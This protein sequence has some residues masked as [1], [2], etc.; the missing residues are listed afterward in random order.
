MDKER[1][2]R[3]GLHIRYLENVVFQLSQKATI[4][5]SHYFKELDELKRESREMMNGT[6]GEMCSEMEGRKGHRLTSVLEMNES[7]LTPVEEKVHRAL[8]LNEQIK[9]E[10]LAKWVENL[11]IQ[12]RI[13]RM[14]VQEKEIIP[15]FGTGSGSGGKKTLDEDSTY[16][17]EDQA[18]INELLEQIKLLSNQVKL[19]EMPKPT[20]VVEKD[21]KWEIKAETL[22]KQVDMLQQKIGD[23]SRE[24]MMLDSRNRALQKKYDDLEKRSLEKTELQ[25]HTIKLL[26]NELDANELGKQEKVLTVQKEVS[27]EKK[28]ENQ[29]LDKAKFE[30]G[31]KIAELVAQNGLLETRVTE[32]QNQIELLKARIADEVKKGEKVLVELKMAHSHAQDIKQGIILQEGDPK[33]QSRPSHSKENANQQGLE[34]RKVKVKQAWE[35][36]K[37]IVKSVTRPKTK[38]NPVGKKEKKGLSKITIKYE[39]SNNAKEQNES[40]LVQSIIIEME[41]SVPRFE[42][43]ERAFK[44]KKPPIRSKSLNDLS[45][46]QDSVGKAMM[47]R[48]KS[49]PLLIPKISNKR[50]KAFRMWLK[51]YGF[52]REK[53]LERVSRRWARLSKQ[54]LDRVERRKQNAQ[55]K[56]SKYFTMAISQLTPISNLQNTAKQTRRNVFHRLQTLSFRTGNESKSGKRV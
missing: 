8:L 1:I 48:V 35:K 19:T 52:E 25:S 26:Q 9:T 37:N 55:Q 3:C 36:D 11:K 32:Q 54:M 14:R 46:G 16:K 43:P 50:D 31:K 10:Q 15:A 53:I 13:E 23:L 42:R 28:I 51:E 21:I 5:R 2:K 39:N 33:V 47:K 44:N 20:I 27:K 34:T 17:S 40:A 30:G 7:V 49:L 4:Q 12:L 38:V 24:N 29:S 6:V 56:G 18:Y 22:E 41:P 45:R